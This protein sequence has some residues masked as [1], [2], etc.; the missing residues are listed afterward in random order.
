M[1]TPLSDQWLYLSPQ[2]LTSPG[3]WIC[4][5]VCSVSLSLWDRCVLCLCLIDDWVSVYIR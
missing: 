1:S 2:Y 4:L 3:M 5:R